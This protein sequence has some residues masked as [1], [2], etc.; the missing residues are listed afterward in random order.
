MSAEAA[1][2]S[3]ELAAE[4]QELQFE[5]LDP[6]DAVRLGVIAAHRALSLGL[7]VLI[8]IQVDDRV[9][10]RSALAGTS[11]SNDDWLRRKFAVVRRFQQ[12]SLAMRVQYEEQGTDFHTATGLPEADYAAYG[13]GWPLIVR[14]EG[15]VGVMGVSGLP[16]LEDHRLIVESIRAFLADR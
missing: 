11:S 1:P 6:D 5:S 12:T 3:A 10:F 13:G 8:E 2:G 14:G 4:L 16:H 15:L 9:I 7:P